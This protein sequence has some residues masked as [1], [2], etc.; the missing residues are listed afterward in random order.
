MVALLLL[1]YSKG[2]ASIFG[3]SDEHVSDPNPC[4]SASLSMRVRQRDRLTIWL[5]A[6]SIYLIDFSVNAAMACS[7]AILVDTLAISEQDL[8]NAWAGRMSVLG[9]I[10][11]FF[12]FVKIPG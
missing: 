6:L 1:G 7:R 8:G 11:G 9:S 2:V 3:L 12:M 5:A 4:I 10:A